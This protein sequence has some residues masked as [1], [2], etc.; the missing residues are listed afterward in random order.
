MNLVSQRIPATEIMT[1]D[2]FTFGKAEILTVVY[3]KVP[4]ICANFIHKVE[5]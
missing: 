5:V 1:G 3:A 2:A 4:N